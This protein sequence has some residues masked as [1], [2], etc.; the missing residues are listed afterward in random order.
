[1]LQETQRQQQQRIIRKI[2]INIRKQFIT[3]Y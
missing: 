3:N 1:M 2:R